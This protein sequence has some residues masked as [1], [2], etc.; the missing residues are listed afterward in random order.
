MRHKRKRTVVTIR[1]PADLA[2]K[3]KEEAHKQW[4]SRNAYIVRILVKG[5]ENA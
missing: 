1:M 5:T 2:D 3:L 4:I